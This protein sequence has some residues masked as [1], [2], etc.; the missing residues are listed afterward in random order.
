MRSLLIWKCLGIHILALSLV[1]LV[2][3]LALDYLA[4]DYFVGLARQYKIEPQALHDIFLNAAHRYLLGAGLAG[5]VLTGLLSFFLLRRALRPL[6]KLTAVTRKFGSGDRSARAPVSSRDELGE[7]AAAFNQMA[8]S[9]Q[10]LEQLRKDMLV[11]VAHELRTPLTNMRGYLEGLRD[12]VVAPSREV[13]ES[14]HEEALRLGLLIEDLLELGRADV[15]QMN[16][17]RTAVSLQELALQTLGLFRLK[18]AAKEVEVRT[19]LDAA[20]APVLA[21]L[22]KLTQVFTNLL[23]NAWQ[24]TPQGGQV[25]ITAERLPEGV[26]I[27]FANTGSVIA[28]E[29]LPV[30]F[31][32]FYRGERSRSREYGGAGLG[33]AIV[34]QLV[35]A[36]GGTVGADSSPEQTRVW[37][38]LPA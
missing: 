10:R 31:E 27:V 35:E 20:A 7:L 22:E 19:S 17:R 2:I 16:L 26:K 15:A 36:H 38:T 14:L 32:R 29:D 23:D 12:A 34:K 4:A 1:I 11:N 37:F 5:L 9:V 21:D 30:I 6:F 8:D 24:Y 28:A 18:F 13:F 25:T 3:W 33:L